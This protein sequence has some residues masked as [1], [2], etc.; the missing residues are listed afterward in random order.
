MVWTADRYATVPSLPKTGHSSL[1]SMPIATLLFIKRILILILMSE[2]KA[3]SDRVQVT[4][5]NFR[6][7]RART[8]ATT[9]P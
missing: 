8:P 2:M 9:T 4:A 7:T 5:V 1:T 6:L 3:S